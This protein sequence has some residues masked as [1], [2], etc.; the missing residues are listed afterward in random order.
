[1]KYAESVTKKLP[2]FLL[3]MLHLLLLF[4]SGWSLPPLCT[5]VVNVVP[6][7]EKCDPIGSQRNQRTY[8]IYQLM[9][10]HGSD[11]YVA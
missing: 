9:N 3:F 1:M 11:Y 8:G 4:L 7:R 2:T 6:Q 10:N 5:A